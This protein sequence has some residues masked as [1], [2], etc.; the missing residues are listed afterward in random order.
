M[1]THYCMGKALQSKITVGLETLDCG[2]EME[3]MDH[4]SEDE[5]ESHCCDNEFKSLDVADDYQSIQT[6][7]SIDTPLAALLLVSFFH[8]IPSAETSEKYLIDLSPPPKERD[9]QILF[10]SFII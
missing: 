5:E 9:L 1:V 3:G 6:D 10:Q 2:M 4:G 7:Y 8:F